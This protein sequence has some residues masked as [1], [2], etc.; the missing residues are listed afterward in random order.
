MTNVTA[1]YFFGRNL[2]DLSYTAENQEILML[3]QGE[4]DD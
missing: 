1:G 4:M 2:C 3:Q